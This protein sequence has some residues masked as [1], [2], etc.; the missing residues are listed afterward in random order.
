MDKILNLISNLLSMIPVIITKIAEILASIPH[1][2][3]NTAP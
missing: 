2:F 1:D 3:S